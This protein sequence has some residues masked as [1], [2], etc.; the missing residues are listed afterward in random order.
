MT[1][2]SRRIQCGLVCCMLVVASGLAKFAHAQGGGGGGSIPPWQA[3]KA[4]P[5]P[6]RHPPPQG[7]Q[8][9]PS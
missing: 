4:P 2:L 5:L 8:S 3:G 7:P 1:S 6:Q 9:E